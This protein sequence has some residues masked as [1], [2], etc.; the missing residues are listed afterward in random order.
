MEQ[1]LSLVT[2]GVADVARAR[3]FYEALGWKAARASQD[4]VA[5]FQ[6]GGMGLSLYSREAIAAD[7]DLPPVGEGFS[8]VTLAQN[9]ASRE[10]VDALFHEMIFAG[11][12][13]LKEPQAIFWGGY[14]G[15]VADP[16]GHVWELAHN[17]FFALD[18]EG[19]LTIDAD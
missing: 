15:F 14:V 16:D 8:G 11:G 12:R 1:R 2:L 10:A 3:A 13:P 6:L 18:A 17:P 5:F 9:L 7:A 19:R 4:G